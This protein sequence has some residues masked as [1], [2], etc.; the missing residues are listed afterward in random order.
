MSE[1][2]PEGDVC[3]VLESTGGGLNTNFVVT[4]SFNELSAMG[5]SSSF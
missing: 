1:E 3:V 4:L 5:E 2:N